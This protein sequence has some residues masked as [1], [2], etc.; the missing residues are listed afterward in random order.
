MRNHMF[1]LTLSAV[2]AAVLAIAQPAHADDEVKLSG[3]LVKA[4]DGD[5]YL[6]T[7]GPGEPALNRSGEGKVSPDAFGASG[8]YSTIVYWLDDDNSLK[9]HVGHRVEVEGDLKGEARDGEIKVDRKDR[10]TELEIKSNGRTM[11]ANVP[12]SSVVP[13]K[14]G[15]SRIL[16]RR[17]S[18]E[19]VKML[20]AGCGQ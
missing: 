20:D 4:S 14:D 18:V 10:W 5:G 15:K 17:V 1:T 6:V 16:V 12:N 8:D 9:P 11:H 7:N 2:A 13:G 19:K 3:C